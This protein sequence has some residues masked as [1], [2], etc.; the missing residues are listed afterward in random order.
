M[1]SAVHRFRWRI[2]RRATADRFLALLLLSASPAYAQLGIGEIRL[3]VK[4]ASGAPIPATGTLQSIATGIHRSFRTDRAGR[5]TLASLPFGVYRLEVASTGFASQ[6]LLIELR[7][8][9]PIDRVVAMQVSSIDTTIVVED[10]ATILDPRSTGAAQYL[11]P[12]LLEYRPIAAPG[13]SVLNVVNTEPGW[14]VEANGVL[15]PRG[16][17]YG[18]QYV[19]DGTPL[20]DNRSPAFA[21]NL[22]VDDFELM[23]VRTANF[24]AEFGRKLGGV[25]EINTDRDQTAGFHGNA[26]VA[27]GSFGYGSVFGLLRYAGS[28]NHF[29]GSGEGMV[30]DRYLD[31]PVSQNYSNHSAGN[32]YS[33]RFDRDWSPH[34]STHIYTHSRHTAFQVPNEQL[35]EAAGQRQD[36][37]AGEALGQISHTHQF[38]SK[39]IFQTRGMMRDTSAMLWSNPLSTPIMPR[40]DRSLREGYAGASVA[41]SLGDHEFKI[42]GDAVFSSIRELFSY[43]IVAYQLEGV[44]I[45]D[46]NLPRDFRFTGHGYGTE[47][48][49]FVQDLW[50]R[51]R[52]TLSAGVRF[53]HYRL[54]VDETAWSPRLGLAYHVPSAGLVLRASY[55]R[56]FQSPAVENIL[57]ASANLI[58]SFGDKGAYLQLKP[59]RGNYFEIGFGKSLFG[60]LRLDGTWYR[61]KTVNFADDSLLLNTGVSFPIAFR[62]AEIHGYEARL[63]MPHW[64]PFSGYVSYSNMVGTGYLPVAGGLFLGD[65]AGQLLTSVASFPITQDQ[66]NTVRMRMRIQIH[67]RIWFAFSESYNSG[68]PFEISGP[69]DLEFLSRQYGPEI[70]SQVD[71]ERGRV[72]PAATLDCSLGL[73][74]SHSGNRHFALQGDIAN[75]ADRRNVINFAGVLSGTALQAGRTFA[76]RFKAGF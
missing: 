34:D 29:S 3:E 59:S 19:I 37:T 76:V 8:E 40:Q 72:R 39:V 33:F 74:L 1:A 32:G 75:I 49:G 25:I 63:E 51:G 14:L 41:I 62:A 10:S 27:G 15:H 65:E 69:S 30:T 48:S 58:S 54:A 22:D 5:H 20:Y 24:P 47:Q 64:G 31:A 2:F 71:F 12:D 46:D 66:R 52:F 45:F 16:S 57:L 9:A 38:S 23:T 35:Q 18:V 26:A 6:T 7:S 28:H 21:L 67:P 43:H 56:I 55:D 61:R 13:R 68:L 17:E 50:R 44:P 36:R 11:G 60:K 42:G 73:D 70:L 53:D 4:D